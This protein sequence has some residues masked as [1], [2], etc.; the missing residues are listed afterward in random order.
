LSA[1][2]AAAW[3]AGCATP[4]PQK[5]TK[6]ALEPSAYYPLAV[7]NSWTYTANLLGDRT[8]KTVSITSQEFGYYVDDQNGRLKVDA[9]GLRDDKRYLLREP[10]EVGKTWTS[11]VSV[12]SVERSRVV[13]VDELVN[14]PAGTFEHCV[15]VENRNF[16][17]KDSS[18]LLR[19]TFA[20]HVGII[21]IQTVRETEEKV[22]PQ[23][24]VELVSYKVQ[25]PKDQAPKESAKDPAPAGGSGK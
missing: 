10:L 18:L 9:F 21:R 5:P 7:G 8:Q 2:A 12:Q 24:E 15:T 3:S 11:V 6:A 23:S 1:L 19:T 22:I 16:Q 20:P 4:G 25:P 17:D 13:E 14:V